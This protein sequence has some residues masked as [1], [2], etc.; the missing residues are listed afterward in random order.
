MHPQLYQNGR[1]VPM[2]TAAIELRRKMQMQTK[3]Y[4]KG[5]LMSV[6]W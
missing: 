4:L 3:Y 2:R 1:K 6:R 5:R